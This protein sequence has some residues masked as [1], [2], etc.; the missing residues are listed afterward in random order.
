MDANTYPHETHHLSEPRLWYGFSVAA[1][2]WFVENAIGVIVSAEYCPANAPNWGFAGQ[3]AVQVA[4][5][6]VV[7]ALLIVAISGFAVA[8][9]NWRTLAGRREFAHAEGISREAF[10]SVGGILISTFFIVGIVYS[11]IPLAIL[12]QCM[13]AR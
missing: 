4:V 9:K 8:F 11:G 1:V 12:E 5:G 7:L 13:R 6:I 3:T 2:A 10:M